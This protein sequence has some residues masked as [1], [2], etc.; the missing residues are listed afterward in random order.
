MEGSTGGF[1]SVKST[2]ESNDASIVV[3]K[4]HTST[5]EAFLSDRGSAD[6]I[7]IP[8]HAGQFIVY[9]DES[10]ELNGNVLGG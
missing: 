2:F 7:A 9:G 5:R 4:L 10:E 8:C 1:Q 3:K 6:G